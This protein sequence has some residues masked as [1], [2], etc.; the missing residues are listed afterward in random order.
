[1]NDIEM[2]RDTIPTILA[3][4][5]CIRDIVFDLTI[6]EISKQIQQDNLNNYL[7]AVRETI[8]KRLVKLELLIDDLKS[9][10][11]KRCGNCKYHDDFSAICCNRDSEWRAD[12]TDKEFCCEWWMGKANKSNARKAES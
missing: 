8:N 4:F 7:F 9:N 12:F 3:N 11:V 1:M 2:W 6:D 5:E 10:N